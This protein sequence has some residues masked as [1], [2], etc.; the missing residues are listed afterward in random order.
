MNLMIYHTMQLC[1]L[2]KEAAKDLKRRR[3]HLQLVKLSMD[4]AQHPM[5]VSQSSRHPFNSNPKQGKRPSSSPIGP[6]GITRLHFK[7]LQPRHLRPD[8]FFF[9]SGSPRK[10]FAKSEPKSRRKQKKPPT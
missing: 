5:I 8:G 6:K 4:P 3:H 2:R 1:R 9:I 10:H 7:L